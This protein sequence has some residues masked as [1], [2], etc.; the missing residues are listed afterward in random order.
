[1]QAT[2][3]IALSDAQPLVEPKNPNYLHVYIYI[4]PAKMAMKADFMTSHRSWGYI[5]ES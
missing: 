2:S 5:C 1:M 3:R 4:Y